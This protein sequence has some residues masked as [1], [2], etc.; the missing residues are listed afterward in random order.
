MTVTGVARSNK[1]SSK[2]NGGTSG[3]VGIRIA[4]V[5]DRESKKCMWS[6]WKQ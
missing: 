6:L 5:V 4:V 1:G 3:G 2:E